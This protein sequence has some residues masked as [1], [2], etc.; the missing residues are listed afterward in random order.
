MRRAFILALVFGAVLVVSQA[1][2]QAMYSNGPAMSGA[3]TAS[4]P[5][6]MPR[7]FKFV[8]LRD[9]I[10]NIASIVAR[11]RRTQKGSSSQRRKAG[12][13]AAPTRGWWKHERADAADEWLSRPR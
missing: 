9:P 4:N 6:S 2:G 8:F 3:Q 13:V 5:A 1:S 7:L 11:R 10:F 12:R